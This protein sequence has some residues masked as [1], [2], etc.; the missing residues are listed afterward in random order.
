MLVWPAPVQSMKKAPLKSILFSHNFNYLTLSTGPLSI[1]LPWKVSCPHL[2]HC[3]IFSCS[4]PIWGF[5]LLTP[6]HPLHSPITADSPKRPK[7]QIPLQVPFLL[8][9]LQ[10]C[11]KLN[12]ATCREKQKVNVFSEFKYLPFPPARL[13]PDDAFIHHQDT[14]TQILLSHSSL[15]PCEETPPDTLC[16]QPCTKIILYDAP[17]HFPNWK[18]MLHPRDWHLY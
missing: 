12:L 8:W 13:L 5:N 10:G 9:Q 6:S 14:L 16:W 11:S 17:K 7:G 1:S 18:R 3:S 4:S 2:Q 15:I